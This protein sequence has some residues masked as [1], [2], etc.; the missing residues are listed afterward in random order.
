MGVYLPEPRGLVHGR[1]R[2]KGAAV[3]ETNAGHRGR[4]AFQRLDRFDGALVRTRA[5]FPQD[6]PPHLHQVVVTARQSDVLFAPVY[7]IE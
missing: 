6:Q 2:E 4:V 3:V 5:L 7:E 1:G